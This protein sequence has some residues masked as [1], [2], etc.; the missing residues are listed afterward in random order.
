ME[1]F[2]RDHSRAL[3]AIAV[4]ALLVGL[5]VPGAQLRAQE[6]DNDGLY[7]QPFLVL[8]PDMHTAP[9]RAM[10]TDAAGRYII[11]GSEDK[12][13][14]VW[15]AHDGRLLPS[16]SRAA[17]AT[18]ARSIRLQYRLMVIRLLLRAGADISFYLIAPRDAKSGASDHCRTPS[19]IRWCFRTMAAEFLRVSEIQTEA[20]VYL[21]W[22]VGRKLHSMTN[23][24]ERSMG[25]PST[26]PGA[27]RPHHLMASFGSMT[28]I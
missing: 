25:F 21:T 3:S 26:P 12:S 27:S 23:I 1:T 14:R 10:V 13:V 7:S 20:S 28:L 17:R 19:L 22:T 6:V 15:S 9:I 11:T 18:R 2:R 16:G 5:L 4:I 8:D 24:K